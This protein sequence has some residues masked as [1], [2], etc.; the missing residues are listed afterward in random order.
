MFV[1][2]RRSEIREE[3]FVLA[4]LRRYI[5]SGTLEDALMI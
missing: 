5:V 2:R 1:D 4:V 3:V